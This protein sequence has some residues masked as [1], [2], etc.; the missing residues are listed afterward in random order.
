MFADK[1]L[2]RSE[3]GTQSMKGIKK[4]LR[5]PVQIAFMG[6]SRMRQVYQSLVRFLEAGLG[7]GMQFLKINFE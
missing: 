7:P 3:A 2:T 1:C 4:D 5:T 6:D